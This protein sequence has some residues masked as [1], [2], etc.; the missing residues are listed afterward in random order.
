VS[1]PPIGINKETELRNAIVAAFTTLFVSSVSCNAAPE[2]SGLMGRCWTPEQLAG[3]NSEKAAHATRRDT[4]MPALDALRVSPISTVG[5][6]RRVKLPPGRKLI[7]LTF[8][9]CETAHE[10]SGYDGAVIDYLRAN[11][12]KATFFVG[13]KW[14]LDHPERAAQLLADPRFEIGTHGWAH[15]NL[16]VATGQA[17]DNE[18]LGAIAAYG[19]TRDALAARSCAN[20]AG[21][22][23]IPY[24]PRLFRFPFGTCHAEAMQAVAHSGQLAIQWDV[25]SGDPDKSASPARLAQGVIGSA[26]PGSIIV[27]HANGRGWQTSNALPLIIPEMRR[28]GYEF[29]TVSELIAAGTPEIAST[30]YERHPGDNLRYDVARNRARHTTPSWSPVETW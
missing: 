28:R 25:V 10:V 12:V 30:C 24:Q 20:G 1:A 14:M 3:Q 13:G 11:Q 22:S 23:H 19:T 18:I 21:M 17:V 6:V 4:P 5:T 9:V 26:K 2:H 27:A 15:I 16:H 8:D 29:V 7:A